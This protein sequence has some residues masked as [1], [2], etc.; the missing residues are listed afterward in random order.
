[1][2]NDNSLAVFQ[3]RRM[4]VCVYIVLGHQIRKRE[5]CFHPVGADEN[6]SLAVFQQQRMSVC[7]NIVLGHQIQTREDFFIQ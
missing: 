3:Q 1:M 7:V 2:R 4:G 6:N 5:D